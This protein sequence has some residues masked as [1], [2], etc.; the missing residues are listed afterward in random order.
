MLVLSVFD[1]PLP[2]LLVTGSASHPRVSTVGG[3]G[4]EAAGG[5][6]CGVTTGIGS[7]T[8]GGAGWAATE[9]W[10]METETLEVLELLRSR[11]TVLATI[12]ETLD[13]VDTVRSRS[14]SR[15]LRSAVGIGG[16]AV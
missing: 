12:V 6:G 16:G 1:F 2:L 11:V 5:A 15:M 13:V 10:G 4:W 7:E 14:F 9:G 3:T 8:A